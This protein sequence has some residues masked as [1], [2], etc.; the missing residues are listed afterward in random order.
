MPD[1]AFQALEQG[2]DSPSL[3]ILAGLSENEN[4]FLIDSY[5]RN[6]LQELSIKL[7]DKR[8]AAI[9]VGLTIA[10]EIFDGKR[11]IFQGVRDIRSEALDSYPFFEEN[12]Q[13]C[14]DSIGFEKIY[15]LY[16]TIEDLRDAGTTQW[17][18]D[19]TNKELEEELTKDLFIELKIWTDR[20]LH[21]S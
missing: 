16:T 17:Q 12:I 1:V 14:Y 9:D 10:N 20:L 11:T 19:K 6:A 3:R 8:Q 2:M 18:S 7:P 4:E 15:G 13:Y 5:F 21:G